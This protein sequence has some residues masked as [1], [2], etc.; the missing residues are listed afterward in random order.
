[1]G[2]ENMGGTPP[3]QQYT[4]ETGYVDGGLAPP[5]QAPPAG[6]YA[7]IDSRTPAEAAADAHTATAYAAAMSAP[8][9]PGAEVHAPDPAHATDEVRDRYLIPL[10]ELY[11]GGS[12]E[13]VLELRSKGWN[14]R[15][16]ADEL[17]RLRRYQQ[18][19]MGIDPDTDE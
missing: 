4:F 17:L 3:P 2:Y 8:Q 16:I 18:D 14:R 9:Q 1:M 12:R 13:V 6:Q 19:L 15:E 5:E 11:G 7:G 10:A